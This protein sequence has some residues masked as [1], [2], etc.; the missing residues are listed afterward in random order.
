[1]LEWKLV[2]SGRNGHRA[3]V[4]HPKRLSGT[5][6]AIEVKL[7]EAENHRGAVVLL[8][9]DSEQSVINAKT[10]VDRH[11]EGLRQKEAA[12]HAAIGGR[13]REIVNFVNIRHAHVGREFRI[14]I[15]LQ[16]LHCLDHFH[17][18]GIKG[19]YFHAAVIF[20]VKASPQLDGYFTVVRNL[21]TVTRLQ[22]FYN[23]SIP[24]PHFTY[25]IVFK[26]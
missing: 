26:T 10:V 1:M 17:G 9:I 13:I 18:L 12:V 14:D 19:D 21:D 20:K 7:V 11:C 8:C 6:V 15:I 3:G 5:V 24:G 16:L 25:I 23:F 4:S 2:T 22:T